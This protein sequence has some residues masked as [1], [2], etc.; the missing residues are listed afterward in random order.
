MC[1][2]VWVWSLIPYS[3]ALFLPFF[4]VWNLSL[5]HVWVYMWRKKTYCLYWKQILYYNNNNLHIV[6]AIELHQWTSF[7]Y[8]DSDVVVVVDIIVFVLFVEKQMA[9]T[10]LKFNDSTASQALMKFNKRLQS[11]RAS[12][13]RVLAICKT[14]IIIF[15]GIKLQ[16]RN[17]LFFSIRP[18]EKKMFNEILNKTQKYCLPGCCFVPFSHSFFVLEKLKCE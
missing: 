17:S 9:Q 5:C 4:N 8:G 1:V 14:C 3:G 12:G 18:R 6:Q 16:G 13:A 11:K 7:L 15:G 10:Q 2:S